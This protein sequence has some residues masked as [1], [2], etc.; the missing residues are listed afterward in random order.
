MKTEKEI[1]ALKIDLMESLKTTNNPYFG[2][3]LENLVLNNW[4]FN[5]KLE[6]IFEKIVLGK[7]YNLPALW[8]R[9]EY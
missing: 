4:F 2:L 8:N 9:I 6:R 5:I 7:W 1:K 3:S